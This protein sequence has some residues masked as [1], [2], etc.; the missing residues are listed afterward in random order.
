MF[1]KLIQTNKNKVAEI[2]HQ[3]K[4]TPN[5]GA[6]KAVG[7]GEDDASSQMHSSHHYVGGCREK[8]KL[9]LTIL[10]VA[11]RQGLVNY[12]HPASLSCLAYIFPISPMPMMPTTKFSMAAASALSLFSVVQSHGSYP[13]KR[14]V[15]GSH[16]W[17]VMHGRECE[18]VAVREFIDSKESW[19][20]K[21]TKSE[22]NTDRYG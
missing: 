9:N 13:M 5:P 7:L 16:L 22:I 12:L 11:Q 2:I 21:Q 17:L 14:L 6:R 10:L 15:S 3:W 20:R 18:N 19:R 1:N 4:S 8:K